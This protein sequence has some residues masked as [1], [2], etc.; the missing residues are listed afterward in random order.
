MTSSDELQEG[1]FGQVILYVFEILPYLYSNSIFPSW[2]IRSKIYGKE[3][4]SLVIP[5]VF[6]LTYQP[7]RDA[8]RNIK[9]KTIRRK[10]LY[11]LGNDWNYLNQLWNTYFKIPNRIE[12]EAARFRNISESLGI[13]FRG[14][15]KV[16]SDWDSNPIDQDDFITLI[17]DFIK[18]HPEI[19]NL[20][21]ATDDTRF[22]EKIKTHFGNL[23]ILNLGPTDFH[24]ADVV[25][26]DI[27]ERA[28]LDC[29]LLSKCKYVLLTSSALSSFA[30]VLNPSLECYR[31][32]ASKIF[33]DVPYFPVAYVPVFKSLDFKC[34]EILLKTMKNDWLNNKIANK[35][36]NHLFKFRKRN[37]FFIQIW[38]IE[39]RIMEGIKSKIIPLILKISQDKLIK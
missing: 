33:T 37:F 5:G 8:L 15:D 16:L 4:D 14:N 18:G 10:H 25:N 39:F 22:V 35:R 19:L 21:I 34:N 9:L 6:E 30:K 27:A 26:K 23:N 36:F 11:G 1:L 13:H 24:K 38:K 2:E 31:V 32:C 29:I 7:S 17:N 28:L 20:F 12:A 3:S